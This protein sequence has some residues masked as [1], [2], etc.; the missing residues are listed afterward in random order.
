MKQLN[1][2]RITSQET[3]KENK[4]IDNYESLCLY[5]LPM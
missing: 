3:T 4:V 5:M 2:Q 1:I